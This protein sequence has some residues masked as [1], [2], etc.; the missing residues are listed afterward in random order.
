MR[1]GTEIMPDD[2]NSGTTDCIVQTLIIDP[3]TGRILLGYH[4]GGMF[5]GNYTGLIGYANDGEEPE[6]A[7]RRVANE[8]SCLTVGDLELRAI[9]TFID[10]EAGDDEE[11][12]FFCK[13]FSGE[14]RG[15]ESMRPEWFA[16]SEIPYDKM[17]ADDEIWYPL[18]LEGKKLRGKFNLSSDMRELLS[19]NLKEV[20][21]L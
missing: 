6:D 14:V 5:A 8:L 4:T 13:R 16:I 10:N 17:P 12:E 7:A 20:D 1:R 2:T 19:H 15:S 11:Y 9:F 3:V 21:N 18:F